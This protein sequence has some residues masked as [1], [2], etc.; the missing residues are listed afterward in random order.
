MCPKC[1]GP[2]HYSLFKIKQQLNTH[3]PIHVR[4]VPFLSFIFTELV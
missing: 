2:L 3:F 4:N 1:E